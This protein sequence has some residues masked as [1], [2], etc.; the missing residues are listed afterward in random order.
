MWFKIFETTERI[1]MKFYIKW[2]WTI[3]YENFILVLIVYK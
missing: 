3:D 2:V 1:L